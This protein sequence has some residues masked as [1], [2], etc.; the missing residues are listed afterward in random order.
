MVLNHSV[1]EQYVP[2]KFN[3]EQNYPNPFNGRTKI[4]Y[5]V[6]YKTKVVIM[7]FNSDGR[8]LE[9]VI[10]KE[11]KAGVYEVEVCLD[12][13]PDGIYFYQIITNK[14][15]ETRYMELRNWFYELYSTTHKEGWNC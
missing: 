13:L 7:V 4:K 12:K 5:N 1:M 14:F 10:N 6:P 8:I 11:Q 9:K 2:I 3:L 15:T